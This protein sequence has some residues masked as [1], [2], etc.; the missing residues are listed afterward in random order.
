MPR[1]HS[2]RTKILTALTAALVSG[3]AVIGFVA[4]SGDQGSPGSAGA[5]GAPGAQGVPGAATPGVA[6]LAKTSPEPAGA[7]CAN[8][9]TMVQF[10][11]D[12]NGNGALDA[13]EVSSTSYVCNGT[14]T[15]SLV[16][17]SVEGPGM[18]C[19]Y[20]GTKI[21]TGIDANN[22]NTLD[23][24]EI[25]AA[26]TTY[27]CNGAPGG[28]TLAASSG[29]AIAIKPGGV[30]TAVGSPISV[31]FTLKD[32]RGFPV[33]MSGKYSINSVISGRFAVGYFTKD[34][35]GNVSPLTMYSKSGASPQPTAYTAGAAGQGT[36]AENGIGAGDYTYTFPTTTTT[37]GAVAVAYDAAQMGESHVVWIQAARQTDLV[38]PT[39]ANT[40]YAANQGFY[41]VPSN[42]TATPAVRQIVDTANCNK[43]HDKFKPE[44]MSSNAFHSGGR[45][46]A[47]FCNVCHNPGHTSNP[48][49]DSSRFVHRIHRGEKLQPANQFHGIAATYPQDLRN[50]DACHKNA[51]Q[52]AQAYTK[53]SRMACASCHDYVKFDGSAT[54]G[55][56][57]PP[58]A[59]ANG[60]PVSC[61]HIGGKMTD[62]TLCH[63][64]HWPDAI[65]EKHIPVQLPDLG[66]TWLGGTN[67]NTNAAFLAATSYVPTG[68]GAVTYD[69]KS[70]DAWNDNGTKRP[71]ITFKLK[72]NGSDVVFQ[73]YAA[74]VTTE[75]MPNFMGS[76][77][78]YFAFAMPQDGITTPADFN[79]TESGYIRNIWNGTATGQGAG[80]MS[81]PDASG[82]YTIKLTG[83]QVPATATMLTG[84]V[85]YSYSLA[86]TPPLTQ[87]NLSAYPTYACGANKCGGLIV[88][89]PN[90]WKVATGF[91]G[92]RAIVDTQKCNNCHAGLGA[93]PTFHA[94]QRNDGPTCSF[95]H[96]QNRT[97]SGW[98]AGSKYFIHAIHGG[99]QRTVPYVWHASAPGEGFGD[100]EFPA[101]L[102]DCKMCHL[103]NTYDF[104]ASAS[105]AALA[106]LPPVTAA[107][108]KYDSKSATYYTL[109]PYIVADNTTDYGTGYAFNAA[110]G[111]TTE[112][113]GAS[114]VLSPI[115]GVCSAC[116]D[117]SAAVSHMR[118]NGGSFYAPRSTYLSA[119]A[120]KEQCMICHGPGRE[121]AI[122]SVHPQ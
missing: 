92:R 5:Q 88:P 74:G 103:P 121:A 59:D 95:C 8:G 71:S 39:N 78:V 72:L 113:S 36:V 104:T 12:A 51:A 3:A 20:G 109:S 69:I 35:A 58:V 33:D 115:T 101:P 87:T 73:T 96:T 55:C 50:C 25:N 75:L 79:A 114:A 17:S 11:L 40:F 83:V 43:C 98:Q 112:A 99:R 122:G 120:P 117:S 29:L 68:A 119:S 41:Y 2:P 70:V 62:D 93:A 60:V 63:N 15:S 85:G 61:L 23:A 100:V 37:G 26:A 22:D 53:P 108:G 9:G 38:F 7:H 81:G 118:A 80:T 84:G 110:T 56:E 48:D 76:P 27:A 94:G 16:K 32:D 49:A 105:L 66:A 102:N 1:R 21:E 14:G 28:G 67:A 65:K 10:G 4:C 64:C 47:T 54:A 18:N 44:T 52:G 86:S 82:Y 24:G 45:V 89:A 13:S 30:S 97:S 42:P 6:A 57:N 107:T 90:V 46:D 77:S 91:T 106:N 116:H 111:A 34:A 19:P 31:R